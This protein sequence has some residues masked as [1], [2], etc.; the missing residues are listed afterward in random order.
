[1]SATVSSWVRT[2]SAV[3]WAKTVRIVAATIS[4]EP[5]GITVKTL[6]TKWTRQRCQAA[7]SMTLR[8]A[9]TGPLWLSEMTRRTPLRPRRGSGWA[10][11]RRKRTSATV[12]W[13]TREAAPGSGPPTGS[14][15]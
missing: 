15:P 3:G 6:R 2:A 10:P 8:I 4:A 9:L 12:M 11:R 1:M 13:V 5:F 14:D 7:P